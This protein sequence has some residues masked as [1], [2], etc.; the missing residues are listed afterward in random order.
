VNHF[1][2]R[3]GHGF[4]DGWMGESVES[5]AIQYASGLAGGRESLATRLGVG[6]A[7]LELWLSGQEQ[8]P[9]DKLLALLNVILESMERQSA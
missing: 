2:V 6:V 9:D 1:L 3:T 4:D 8:M 5:Q 7:T